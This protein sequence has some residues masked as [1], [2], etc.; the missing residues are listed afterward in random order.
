M[1]KGYGEEVVVVEVDVFDVFGGNVFV[2]C[3]F[4]YV[5][6][7]VDDFEVVYVV[8]FDDVVGV[9]LFVGFD[10]FGCFFGVVVVFFEDDGIVYE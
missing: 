9:E 4:E 7:V 3:E 1:Y 2:L 5:F 10:C 8:Y 6:F